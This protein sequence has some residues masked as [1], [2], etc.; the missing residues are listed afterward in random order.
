MANRQSSDTFFAWL[1]FRSRATIPSRLP[2]SCLLPLC[3]TSQPL[4]TQSAKLTLVSNHK[5]FLFL[6]HSGKKVILGRELFAK[7]AWTE[8]R[9]VHLPAQLPFDLAE[10]GHHV[11]E[12][13]VAHDYQI[14]VARCLFL[15]SRNR[16]VHKG[17]FNSV[18]QSSESFLQNVSYSGRLR[19]NA[20]QFLEDRILA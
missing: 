8:H 4:L 16:A 13:H 20:F 11:L 19:E 12:T 7:L 5:K 10:R 2:L 6:R 15:A 3:A 9:W 18:R 17:K 14:H 1:S